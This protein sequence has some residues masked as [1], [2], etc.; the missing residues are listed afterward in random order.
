GYGHDFESR[1]AHRA[2]NSRT[3][4][5][6]RRRSGVGHQRYTLTVGQALDYG[7]RRRG[8]IMPMRRH[9]RGIDSPGIQKRLARAR[10]LRRDDIAT[11]EC[12][13]GPNAEI[14]KITDRRGD[15]VQ[16]GR[17]PALRTYA[18]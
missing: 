18:L 1:L 16:A 7:L 13:P 6:Y 5:A 12:L 15:N 4:V 14:A 17:R 9:Q 3:R 11:G 10:I 8:L 2:H